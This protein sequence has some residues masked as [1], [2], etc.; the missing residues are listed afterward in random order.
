MLKN[1]EDLLREMSSD[2]M[3]P[4]RELTN[5]DDSMPAALL[6]DHLRA[7]DAEAQFVF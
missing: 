1:L 3:R 2:P 7:V 5:T 4:V 6:N